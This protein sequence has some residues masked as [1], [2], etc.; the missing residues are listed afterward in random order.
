MNKLY[1]IKL[2]EPLEEGID[3]RLVRAHN[4]KEARRIAAE[5]AEDRRG[6]PPL[7]VPTH[8]FLHPPHRHR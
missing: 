8:V 1:I 6:P 3:W 4:K 5:D 2:D 7:E